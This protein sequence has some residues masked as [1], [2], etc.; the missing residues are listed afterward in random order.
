MR[1]IG[2][3]L[4]AVALAMDAFA[5]SVCK[6]FSIRKIT[7]SKIIIVG[8]YFSVFQALMPLI[9][10]Y[11]A[12]L[13]SNQILEYSHWIAFVLL[14]VLGVKML[15]ESLKKGQTCP[16]E[17]SG[18]IRFFVMLPLAIATSLDAMTAGVSFSFLNVNMLYAISI[19]GIVTFIICIIGV[20]IGSIFGIKY[21]R[22]AEV[23]GGLILIFIGV[24]ILL[25]HLEII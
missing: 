18:S 24:R 21:Q 20:K 14:S 9:G 6:G 8:V 7:I 16:I 13:F 11:L 5:V 10:Y 4:I 23:T 2:L 17:S 15:I 3:F 1:I 22:K 12:N 25:E 19:I